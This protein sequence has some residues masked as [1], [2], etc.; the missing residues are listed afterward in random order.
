MTDAPT[1]PAGY[2][3]VAPGQLACVVTCLEM[4]AP[5]AP[6]PAPPWPPGMALERLIAPEPAAYRALFRAVG[7]DWLWFSRLVMPDGRL[8]AIL[9]DPRVEV[10]ALRQ[11][12]ED[13]GILEL[14]FREP[15][16]CELAFFG[17]AARLTGQGLGRALMNAALEIAWSRPIG[18]MWVHT[19]TFDHPAAVA[20]YRR[21][22]FAPY[23]FQVEVLDDPRLSGHLP[24]DAAPHVPLLGG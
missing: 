11:G 24:R 9:G 3:A 8:R 14:D 12:G 13:A 21:S 16:V 22:G 18:R 20:F 6:R 15:G 7:Q 23:A 1:L 17:L 2:S 4:R 5:P 10:R 19:C